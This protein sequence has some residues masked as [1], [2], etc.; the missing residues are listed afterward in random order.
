MTDITDEIAMTPNNGSNI[1]GG[2]PWHLDKRIPI[3]LILTIFVQTGGI[4]WWASRT[5]SR[6]STAETSIAV[7]QRHDEEDRRDLRNLSIAIERIDARLGTIIDALKS[8]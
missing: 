7:L 5:D 6:L 8:R 4:I 3:T 2:E 1:E